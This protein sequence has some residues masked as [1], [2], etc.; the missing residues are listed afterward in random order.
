MCL[1]HF[2]PGYRYCF[3]E[4]FMLLI[5]LSAYYR[6][7]FGFTIIHKF[8]CQIWAWAVMAGCSWVNSSCSSLFWTLPVHL[9]SRNCYNAKNRDH[10]PS[11][12][13]NCHIHL[14]KINLKYLWKTKG[15]M[16]INGISKESMGR[17]SLHLF[18]PVEDTPALSR[19]APSI[20]QIK[21]GNC[22]YQ[23]EST[24]HYGLHRLHILG[25]RR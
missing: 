9:I 22:T 25:G 5:P 23:W 3:E 7:L 18:P 8:K 13:G 4:S 2:P 14:R 12:Q 16:F 15:M 1:L 21:T 20:Y 6:M 19:A 24:L 17:A 11:E 10:E